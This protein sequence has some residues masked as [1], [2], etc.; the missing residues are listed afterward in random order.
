MLKTIR[1]N[2]T[3]LTNFGGRET[4]GQFWPYAAFVVVLAIVGM[5]L[6]MLPEMADSIARMQ[7]FA[8]QHPE[9]ATVQSGPGS[10]S[11]SIKGSHPELMPDMAGMM[12][13]MTIV[14]A[15]AIALLAAA[16]ARR[17]HDRGKSG[18]WGLLPVPFIVFASVAMPKVFTQN[19]PD[20]GLFFAVF[21]N[22]LFYIASLITLIVML[23]GAT[24]VGT[25]RW[26]TNSHG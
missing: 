24:S 6:V 18:F 12:T 14:F 13:R 23:A 19:P 26:D 11:I 16:V 15:V 1:Y 22:N 21:F 3:N 7:R 8:A 17:L 5:A 2:L 4:R 9:L 20:M 10:Y 25:N